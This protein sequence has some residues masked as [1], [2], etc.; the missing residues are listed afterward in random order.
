[1]LPFSGLATN[2]DLF[3]QVIGGVVGF[4]LAELETD[5]TLNSTDVIWI[6]LQGGAVG[7]DGFGGL[8][9]LFQDHREIDSWVGVTRHEFLCP[10]EFAGGLVEVAFAQVKHAEVVV[11]GAEVKICGECRLEK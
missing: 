8:A 5:E 7:S 10:L 1:L 3:E 2:G 9:D 11:G 4:G 6:D